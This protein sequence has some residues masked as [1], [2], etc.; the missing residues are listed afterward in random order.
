MQVDCSAGGLRSIPQRKVK[1]PPRD[2]MP[3]VALGSG[4]LQDGEGSAGEHVGQLPTSTAKL[5]AAPDKWC[6]SFLHRSL[7][8]EAAVRTPQPTHL[9]HAQGE[10]VHEPLL[11]QLL[12]GHA[13]QPAV[14]RVGVQGRQDARC[15]RQESRRALA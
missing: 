5:P 9:C 14:V 12:A 4:G 13:Q 6:I 8:L 3:L 15:S 7:A 1:Q 2:A 11:V 10:D